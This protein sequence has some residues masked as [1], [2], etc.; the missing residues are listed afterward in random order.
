MGTNLLGGD[1]TGTYLGDA[2]LECDPNLKDV[3]TILWNSTMKWTHAPDATFYG[4]TLGCA[5][6]EQVSWERANLK[7][8]WLVGADL[9]GADLIDADLSQARLEGADLTGA[10]LSPDKFRAACVDDATTLPLGV[11]RPKPCDTKIERKWETRC[12]QVRK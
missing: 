5:N 7:S 2:H 6:L 11:Q 12:H 4:A 1:L 9:R 8:A 10:H 3:C